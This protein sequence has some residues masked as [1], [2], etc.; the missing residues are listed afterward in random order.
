MFEDKREQSPSERPWQGPITPATGPYDVMCP[1]PP[2]TREEEQHFRSLVEEMINNTDLT[3]PQ[4][5]VVYSKD[6]LENANDDVDDEA[7]VNM[8]LRNQA[9]IAVVKEKIHMKDITAFL[10]K[11]SRST[12]ATVVRNHKDV[13]ISGQFEAETENNK[14]QTLHKMLLPSLYLAN[15]DIIFVS[16]EDDVSVE[17]LSYIVHQL[18]TLANGKLVLQKF[19]GINKLLR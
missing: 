6:V 12:I 9:R 11:I 2:R 7:A 1:T 18:Q 16:C 15:P 19:T 13:S 4:Y 10:I 3:V 17:T 5:R 8:V 14:V